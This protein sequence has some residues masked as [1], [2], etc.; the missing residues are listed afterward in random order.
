MKA[1]SRHHMSFG[2]RMRFVLRLAGITG[3]L[4]ALAGAIFLSTSAWPNGTQTAC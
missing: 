2:S 3:V 1:D 4:A